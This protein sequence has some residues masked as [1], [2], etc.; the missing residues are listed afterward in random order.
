MNTVINM[1]CMKPHAFQQFDSWEI[2][3]Q[4]KWASTD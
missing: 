4:I 2:A 1:D 3:K